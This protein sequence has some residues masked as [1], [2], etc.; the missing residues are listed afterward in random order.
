MRLDAHQHFWQY[1]PEG[2]PWIQP[3]WPIRRDFLPSDLEPL[4]HNAQFDASIVVQA[5][6][7][8]DESRWLLHL[9]DGHPTIAGVVGWVDL[10]SDTVAEQLAPLAAH[11]KFVGVRHVVQDEPDDRFL[12]REDFVRGVGELAGF[13][14]AYDLLV[15][16]RQLP[17]AIALVQRF[18]KQVFVL[19]HI[20]KPA[21]R[22]G[23][24]IP[25]R[26]RIFELAQAPNVS[27]K[28]SGMVTEADWS[29]WRKADFRPFLDVIFE[30]FGT[31][32]TLFGSDW[33]VC[34][35]AAEYADVFRIVDEYARS[36]TQA[37]REQLFGRAAARIYGVEH[38]ETGPFSTKHS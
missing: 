1:S 18:P 20:A 36:F 30:A 7:S 2:Y 11:P 24:L 12:L 9:A 25:W 16:P 15:F 26:D 27:C 22:D 5:R 29:Q 10:R 19:D 33:P 17:S 32:R 8:L 13:D 3:G 31:A 34:L 28:V 4:L 37:D 21:I 38:A 35:L 14:L 23:T 6:Q